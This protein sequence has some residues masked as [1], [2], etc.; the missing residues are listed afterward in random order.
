MHVNG[1]DGPMKDI[2]LK[3]LPS[4]DLTVEAALKG[5]KQLWADAMMLD[6]AVTDY[7]TAEKLVEDF[8]AEHG[9]YLPQYK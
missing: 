6:G 8:I 4:V 2:I 3:R 9:Q 1:F 5:D 7:E